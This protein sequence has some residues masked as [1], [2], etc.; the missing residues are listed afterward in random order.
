[1][2]RDHRKLEVFHQAHRL[3]LT[4]YKET[5]NFP[6]D[7]WFGARLQLR[8][9]SVSVACNLVEGNARRST[10]E[11]VNFS[12]ISRASASEMAYLVELS[13]ELGYLGND[14]YKRLTRE[15]E[16]LIPRLQALLARWRRCS[17]KNVRRSAAAEGCPQ[18]SNASHD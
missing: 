7:E 12:N 10:R 1:M 4:I 11:Y 5:R 3:T 6:R 13:W 16:A 8:K 17:Q 2:A 9:A 15:C 18:R 14:V